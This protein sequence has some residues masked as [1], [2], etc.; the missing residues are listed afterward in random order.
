[1]ALRATI[2]AAPEEDDGRCAAIR[3][4]QE[5]TEVGIRGDD[6]SSLDGSALHDLGIWGSLHAVVANMYRV[7]PVQSE[8]L[9]NQR[10]E[11]VI[12]QKSHLTAARRLRR[13]RD[14]GQGLLPNGLGG[15]PE[16]FADVLTL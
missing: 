13:H 10:G 4:C 2:C 3:Q 6:H 8:S 14:E 1:M 11:C 16:C 9:G 12:D 5:G 7:V 15:K